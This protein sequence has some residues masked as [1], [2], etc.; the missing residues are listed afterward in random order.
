[1]AAL[2]SPKSRLK[3]IMFD[4][5]HIDPRWEEGRDY[6]MVCGWDDPRNYCERDSS[7]NS[8]KNNRFLPWRVTSDEIGTV[9]VNQGDLC[10]FLV[11]ADIERDIPGEWVLMEFL[12]D[13]W[14]VASKRT[15]AAYQQRINKIGI[16]SEDY[17][18]TLCERNRLL[19]KEKK[20]I[21][22]PKNAHIA[23]ERSK[24]IGLSLFE[25]K[26]GLFDPNHKEKRREASIKAGTKTGNMFKEK[27]LG[28]FDP[29]HKEKKREGSKKGIRVTNSQRWQC[30]VTG[31][32]STP[33]GLSQWQRK[34]GIDTSNRIRLE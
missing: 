26:K 34:R 4:T 24:R 21:H 20:G 29:K 16:F 12:S 11:G 2:F 31:Y 3:F 7:L 32:I 22:D 17:Y 8:S 30:T 33:A 19:V 28:L 9:P 5:D 1:M 15:C 13:E 6:Q 18:D 14:F 27:G 23:S 10:L 25:R